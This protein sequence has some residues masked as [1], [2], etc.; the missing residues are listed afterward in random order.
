MRVN[1]LKWLFTM[2]PNEGGSQDRMAVQHALPCL[3]QCVD[4]Q[5]AFED[6]FHLLKIDAG[7]WG[8]DRVEQH[9]LLHWR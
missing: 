1:Y 2:F 9:A 6:A 7:V 3:F 4:V 8:I 5:F